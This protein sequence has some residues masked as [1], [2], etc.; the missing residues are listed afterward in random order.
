VRNAERAEA[1]LELIARKQRR[2]ANRKLQEKMNGDSS[3]GER[4]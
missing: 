4:V 3:S 1:E 2:A